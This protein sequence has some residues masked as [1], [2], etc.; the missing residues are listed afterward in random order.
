MTLV[1]L[2]EP[3]FQY[4]CKIN[5]LGRVSTNVGP[6][7]TR[8]QVRDE[9]KAILADLKSRAD[10]EGLG[11]Q[12]DRV[13]L[14]LIFFVDSMVRESRL[15]ATWGPQQPWRNIAEERREMAGDESFWRLLDDTLRE[16][17]DSATQRLAVFYTMVGLGFTGIYMNDPDYLRK[18]TREIAARV[19]GLVEND[20]TGRVTPDAYEHV[21]TRTLTQPP[22]RTLVGL[23]ILLVGTVVV[24]V[25][26]YVVS[27]RGATR[28]LDQK[29]TE[30]TSNESTK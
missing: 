10:R 18:K 11:G 3:L 19:R 17:G 14:P 4:I 13:E 5:R 21:D 7:Q 28:D 30:I 24:L 16:P 12:F 22:A 26:S 29:L 8:D 20:Q 27:F 9:I 15:S 23:V 2:C 6:R 1:E 25:V